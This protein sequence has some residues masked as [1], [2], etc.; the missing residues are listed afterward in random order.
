MITDCMSEKDKL[1]V[2]IVGKV[3]T[4]S[5]VEI[6]TRKRLIFMLTTYYVSLFTSYFQWT[7]FFLVALTTVYFTE[8]LVADPN[9]NP[10]PTFTYTSGATSLTVVRVDSKVNGENIA[11][12]CQKINPNYSELTMDNQLQYEVYFWHS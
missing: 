1:K 10:Y 6:G 5:T 3:V 7:F 8:I 9:G 4:S 2:K 12:E 11:A